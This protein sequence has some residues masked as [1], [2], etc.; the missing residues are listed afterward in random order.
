ML[1]N[2]IIAASKAAEA[3]KPEVLFTLTSYKLSYEKAAADLGPIGS[4]GPEWHPPMSAP[5]EQPFISPLASNVPATAKGADSMDALRTGQQ[6]APALGLGAGAGVLAGIPI[7]L[8]SHG[9]FGK[10]KSL[11]GYLRSALMG[12]LIGGGLGAAGGGLAR[13]LYQNNPGAKS[14]IDAGLGSVS[15]FAAKNLGQLGADYGPSATGYVKNV[16][17]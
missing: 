2:Q 11:R 6:Y 5:A 15:D 14:K 9:L 10:D 3:K 13:Y 16:L 17:S 7:A 1:K 4:T 12:S 8:L